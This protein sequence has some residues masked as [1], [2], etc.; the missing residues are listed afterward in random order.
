[1][2]LEELFSRSERDGKDQVYWNNLGILLKGHLSRYD[3]AAQAFRKAIE[4]D[5]KYP[6]AWGNL[7][8]LLQD[9]LSRL[10]FFFFCIVAIIVS[11]K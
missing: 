1:M 11:V 4:L 9:H 8:N 6:D 10:L 7:G 2:V 5:P 3:E